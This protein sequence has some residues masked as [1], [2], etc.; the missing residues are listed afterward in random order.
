METDK[1]SDYVGIFTFLSGALMILTFLMFCF[2]VWRAVLWLR[3]RRNL[4]DGAVAD[5]EEL[6]DP[7]DQAIS[8]PAADNNWVL[9]WAAL[10]ASWV[11]WG[12]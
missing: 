12:A 8:R 1:Y 9:P 11:A 7:W 3:D 10:V 5:I 2:L 4:D 6:K